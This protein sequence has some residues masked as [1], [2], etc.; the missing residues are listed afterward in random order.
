MFRTKRDG[1]A[2]SYSPLE[3]QDEIMRFEGRFT[4]HLITAFTPL[5][6]SSDPDVRRRATRDKLMY[7]S[8]ALDIAVGSAPDVDLL[9]MVTLVA[10][11]ADAMRRRW[12][13]AQYGEAGQDVIA[14]FD[15]ALV[16][17][18]EVARRAVSDE[19]EANLRRVIHEWQVENPHVED[20]ATVR[21]STFAE[22]GDG[23][24]GLRKEAAGLF[25][26][27]RGAAQTADAVVMLGERALYAAQRLPFLLQLHTRVT[28]SDL[29]ADFASNID[30]LDRGIEKRVKRVLTL[31]A[32]ACGGI[33]FVTAASWLLTRLLYDRLAARWG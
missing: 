5:A 31:S 28:S 27:V 1:A 14:A 6:S 9:D 29:V 2:P 10:L 26:I 16:D 17:I 30:G 19:L 15:A 33:V 11:G 7:M 20:V 22:L 18:S 21:L 25:S 23:T 8:A 12:D 24:T 13:V 3:L 32:V 4:S